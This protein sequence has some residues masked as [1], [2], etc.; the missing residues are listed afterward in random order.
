MSLFRRIE[1]ALATIAPAPS[2][3]DTVRRT[4]QLLGGSFSRELGPCGGRVDAQDVGSYELAA[5]FGGVT[6]APIGLRV[7]RDAPPFDVVV[8]VATGHGLPAALPVVRRCVPE[9]VRRV[10]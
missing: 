7:R 4:A 10:A 5:T 1:R 9:D 8:A 6:T 3:L 2:P